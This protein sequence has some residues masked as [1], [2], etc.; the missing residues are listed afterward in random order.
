MLHHTIIS[1]LPLEI[2]HLSWEV[3]TN[4]QVVWFH[5]YKNETWWGILTGIDKALG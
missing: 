4:S 2:S 5:T 1:K 3:N